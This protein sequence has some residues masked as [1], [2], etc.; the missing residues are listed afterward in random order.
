MTLIPLFL[1]HR[2][3]VSFF[4]A[5]M[6]ARAR[7][8]YILKKLKSYSKY[9][10]LTT[11]MAITFKNRPKMN[12]SVPLNSGTSRIFWWKWGT[13]SGCLV[14]QWLLHHWC[15]EITWAW[16]STPC[17][18]QACWKWS[19]G[20]LHTIRCVK[21]L[22][23]D[24]WNLST[25][26]PRRTSL[27]VWQNH[28]VQRCTL[29]WWSHTL[30]VILPNKGSVKKWL[31]WK[32]AGTQKVFC[33]LTN[34]RLVNVWALV[35]LNRNRARKGANT[36]YMSYTWKM[37]HAGVHMHVPIYEGDGSNGKKGLRPITKEA[38]QAT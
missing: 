9:Y 38:Q 37:G 24:L 28:W 22:L 23:Q 29:S 18:L 14:C 13:R 25:S 26:H 17:Y 5:L 34:I 32:A 11:W 31:V 35:V 8:N 19:T 20:Q 21:P 4:L 2:H 12:K 1:C 7:Q 6:L 16:C 3:V 30:F 36:C 10:Y 33:H 15:M 27:T